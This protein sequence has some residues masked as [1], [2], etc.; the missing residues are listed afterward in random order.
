MPSREGGFDNIMMVLSKVIM[1]VLS[2]VKCTF[3]WLLWEKKY[4]KHNASRGRRRRRRR[5]RRKRHT[6]TYIHAYI[7]TYIHSSK[8]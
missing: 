4:I 5:R 7:H 6:H 2:K 8:E 3:R 1:M